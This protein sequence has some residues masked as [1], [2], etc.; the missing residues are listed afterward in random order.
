MLSED[1]LML[2]STKILDVFEDVL[3]E[4]D[5][6][7]PSEEREDYDDACIYGNL[8]FEMSEKIENILKEVQMVDAITK[9]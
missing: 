2:F 7:I 3:Q 6:Q 9:L 1:Q 4:Y 8:Y 5:I